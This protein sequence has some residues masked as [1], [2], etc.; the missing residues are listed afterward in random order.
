MNGISSI[1]CMFVVDVL[2]LDV[3]VLCRVV[4]SQVVVKQLKRVRRR[5]MELILA[6]FQ[7]APFLAQVRREGC[8]PV[9]LTNLP[10]LPPSPPST[11]NR[12]KSKGLTKKQELQ[13]MRIRPQISRT[14]EFFF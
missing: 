10:S 11:F 1:V 2:R 8:Y 5:M 13:E 12:E 4:D 6:G 7:R 9:R 14:K 3:C